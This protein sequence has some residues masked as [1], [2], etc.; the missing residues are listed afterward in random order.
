MISNS[1]FIISNFFIGTLIMIVMGLPVTNASNISLIALWDAISFILVFIITILLLYVAINNINYESSIFIKS[2]THFFIQTFIISGMLSTI[3]GMTV[4]LHSTYSQ[5]E[6]ETL[7]LTGAMWS[8]LGTS[9]AVSFITLL[10]GLGFALGSY[11]LY[12][13]FPIIQEQKV[14]DIQ[15]SNQ[16]V[17]VLCIITFFILIYFSFKLSSYGTAIL[18]ST[19]SL[20][21]IFMNEN[22]MKISLLMIILFLSIVGKNVFTIIG[23]FRNKKYEISE[24]N[25][26]L[27]TIQVFMKVNS[28]FTLLLII[29]IF[30]FIGVNFG[31]LINKVPPLLNLMSFSIIVFLITI[32]LSK[33]VEIK[34]ITSLVALNYKIIE[35]NKYFVIQYVCPIFLIYFIIVNIIFTFS[36][37]I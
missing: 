28:I 34:L 35:V 11:I 16:I 23:S 1:K 33:M 31:D 9:L 18:A 6:K 13:K 3:I 21:T 17:S 8:N 26:A 4:V 19:A 12:K 36:F 37:F 29:T 7:E 22:Q 5:I 14:L 25:I 15:K 20:E 2:R 27:N 10:Y 30:I 24:L 32:L